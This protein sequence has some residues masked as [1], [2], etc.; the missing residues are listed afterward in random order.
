M[1]LGITRNL[2]K[3]VFPAD[4]R[5]IFNISAQIEETETLVNSDRD[6]EILYK[7]EERSTRGILK[8]KSHFWKNELKPALIVQN[9]IDNGY[10]MPCITIPPSFNATNN[11][12]NLIN[13]R[14]ISQAISKLLKKN[15]IEE[16]D[17]KSYCCNPL[18]VAE[19]KKLRLV[20][21]LHHIN[22]FIKQNNF[23]YENL[24]LYQKFWVKEIISRLSICHLAII[25]S[26][27]IQNIKNFLVLSGPM[28]MGLQNIFSFVFYH[29]YCHQHVTFLQGFTP[30]Y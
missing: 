27:Y 11:K 3:F 22:S 30:I 7:T 13:S 21:G 18:T 17:Q 19:S 6:W 28:K 16:L 12:S 25:I 26:K 2:K 23:R 1:A 4:K 10:I 8:E 15:C 5:G 14:F 24:T 29:S 20:L 9:M